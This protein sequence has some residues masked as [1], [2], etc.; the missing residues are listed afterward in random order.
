[1]PFGVLSRIR[2]LPELFESILMAIVNRDA[3]LS[4]SHCWPDALRDGVVSFC[5]LTNVI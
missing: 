4:S 3:A 5:D 2:N 1:M